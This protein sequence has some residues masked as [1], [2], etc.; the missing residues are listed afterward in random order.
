MY[1]PRKRKGI[2]SGGVKKRGKRARTAN[3]IAK[4]IVARYPGFVRTGGNYARYG[5]SASAR[6]LYP[7]LKSFD[8]ALGWNFDTTSEVPASGQLA[9][10]A[11]GDTELTRDGRQIVVTSIHLKGILTFTPGAGVGT[12]IVYLYLVLDTQCNGAAAAVTDVLASSNMG[13]ALSQID[14]S[15]RFRILRKWH[16]VFNSGS[17][18]AGAIDPQMKYMEYYTPCN[19]KVDYSG[20]TGA[21]TEIRSNNIFLLAGASALD[22]VVSFAGTARLRFRG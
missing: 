11:Q 4:S 22:D 6:G 12:C 7:E 2:Y 15:Q 18:V 17:G 21:I 10:I 5:Q 20:A 1:N 13:T 8:T 19:I 9:L 14:N 16:W 3:Q